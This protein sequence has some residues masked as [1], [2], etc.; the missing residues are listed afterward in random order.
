MRYSV[1][2]CSI[3]SK[4]YSRASLVEKKADH[5]TGF[6][7][8]CSMEAS[9]A[10]RQRVSVKREIGS[11]PSNAAASVPAEPTSAPAAAPA[12][13][14]RARGAASGVFQCIKCGKTSDDL[15]IKLALIFFYIVFIFPL[16]LDSRGPSYSPLGIVHL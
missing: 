3:D 1:I 8:L 13:A 14:V 15:C 4:T 9:A 12:R 7:C 11:E 6:F 16:E 2:Q 5:Q 10:S